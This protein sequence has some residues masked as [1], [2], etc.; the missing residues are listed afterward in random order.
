MWSGRGRK[1]DDVDEAWLVGVLEWTREVGPTLQWSDRRYVGAE[2]VPP[3]SQEVR[4]RC[5]RADA[6]RWGNGCQEPREVAYPCP[7]VCAATRKCACLGEPGG[8]WPAV[9]RCQPA[10]QLTLTLLAA[11]CPARS[12]ARWQAKAPGF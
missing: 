5:E 12:G 7:R 8:D 2:T 3:P 1:R 9:A 6:G 11:C 10:R 4:L